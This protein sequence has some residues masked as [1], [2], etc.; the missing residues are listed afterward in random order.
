LRLLE[1]DKHREEIRREAH[2]LKGAASTF[3]FQ[4]LSG[5]AQWLERGAADVDS[6]TAVRVVSRME[7]AFAE[8][9]L[10]ATQCLS[11][12]AD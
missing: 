2:T 11:A 1:C 10:L 12:A 8:A 6:E 5:L 7:T 3:G 4:R 9:R